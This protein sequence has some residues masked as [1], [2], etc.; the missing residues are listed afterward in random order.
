MAEFKAKQSF[1]CVPWLITCPQNWKTTLLSGSLLLL[2][3]PMPQEKTKY[4]PMTEAR[5][6]AFTQTIKRK[7]EM[8]KGRE[9]S[10]QTHHGVCCLVTQC[11]S[12]MPAHKLGAGKGKGKI[13]HHQIHLLKKSLHISVLEFGN[14][15]QAQ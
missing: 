5:S 10:S 12:L 15:A 6:K 14:I 11:T 8:E 2:Q 1:L 4:R 7:K 3:S 13:K 9:G